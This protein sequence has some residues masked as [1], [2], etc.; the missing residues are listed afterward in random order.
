MLIRSRRKVCRLCAAARVLE[1]ILISPETGTRVRPRD[2]Y[3]Y[4]WTVIQ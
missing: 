1:K 2:Y 3:Y 4:S